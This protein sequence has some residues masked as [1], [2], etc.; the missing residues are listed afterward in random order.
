M[1]LEQLRPEEVDAHIQNGTFRLAFVGMSNAGKSY[2][3]K[4]LERELDFFWYH[5]DGKIQKALGFEDMNEISDWLGYPNNPTYPKREAEYL[6]LENK[7]TKVDDLNTEGKNL[8]F[9]TTGSVT[10]LNPDTLSWL[11]EHCLI[12][13]LEVDESAIELLLERFVKEPKPV[14]W[15]GHFTPEQDEDDIATIRRCYPSLL[16]ERLEN[17]PKLAHLNIP[18]ASFFDKT[19]VET[20]EIIKSY[21]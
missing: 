4:V 21:L 10:H 7:C 11:H 2:R 13:H 18:A 19:G 14:I 6:A 5:V 1:K 3:S 16:R 9:D 17:Y 20:I 15:G 12:V 8:V